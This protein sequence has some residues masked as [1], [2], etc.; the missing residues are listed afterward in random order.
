[1][2]RR[3]PPLTGPAGGSPHPA[4]TTH[5]HR[6]PTTPWGPGPGPLAGLGGPVGG[7]GLIGSPSRP[8]TWAWPALDGVSSD[9]KHQL[10]GRLQSGWGLVGPR[11][12]WAQGLLG[13]HAPWQGC[14]ALGRAGQSRAE[15]R[16]PE[17][18]VHV[19]PAEASQRACDTP[20]ADA[21][22]V[23]RGQARSPSA[24]PRAD[25]TS[26]T[27]G[28]FH[29]V[30]AQMLIKRFPCR[31]AAAW[32]GGEARRPR[33]CQWKAVLWEPGLRMRA[34]G[35]LGPW[36]RGGRF[37]GPGAPA[38][39][40]PSHPLGPGLFA[41]VGWG[42]EPRGPAP[43]HVNWRVLSPPCG[44]RGGLS[45]L[46]PPQPTSW[47]RA[48]GPHQQPRGGHGLRRALSEGK[49]SCPS[50]WGAGASCF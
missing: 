15:K 17:G 31:G 1:M 32:F 22:S 27:D 40:W 11:D 35:K 49:L 24:W 42:P 12:V 38:L 5:P 45:W 48:G 44:D 8:Q 21:S 20:G 19:C 2:A 18:R 47:G 43:P 41:S 33:E 26:I 46:R 4:G 36:A 23:A 25:V 9:P 28:K 10:V 7:I 16:Q 29:L 3:G 37:P 30:R 34:E 14:R 13:G 6:E 50:L 39:P